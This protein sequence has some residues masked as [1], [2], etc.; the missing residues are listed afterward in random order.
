MYSATP[1][2][3]QSA[4]KSDWHLQPTRCVAVERTA[5]WR[6]Q[7]GRAGELDQRWLA[8][9][10]ACRVHAASRRLCRPAVRYLAGGRAATFGSADRHALLRTCRRSHSS[11]FN[12]STYTRANA[13]AD[14]PADVPADVRADGVADGVADGR[15]ISGWYGVS[16]VDTG[17]VCDAD[18]IADAIYR[19]QFSASDVDTG[20]VRDAHPL[21]IQPNVGSDG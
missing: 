9:V 18:R 1:N 16:D 19:S 10:G 3:G 14:D 6:L 5:I 8:G 12:G 2:K 13:D 11:A 15:A 21:A 7:Q 20:D 17:D 4:A